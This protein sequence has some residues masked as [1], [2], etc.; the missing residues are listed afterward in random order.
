M[1]AQQGR[2]PLPGRQARHAQL[3]QPPYSPLLDHPRHHTSHSHH[4]VIDSSRL[5]CHWCWQPATTAAGCTQDWGLSW[6]GQ[7]YTTQHNLQHPQ[8][9]QLPEPVLL[10]FVAGRYA[11]GRKDVAPPGG[12]HRGRSCAEEEKRQVPGDAGRWL[13]CIAGLAYQ[14]HT[15]KP[16]GASRLGTQVRQRPHSDHT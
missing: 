11:K 9:E 6:L 7:M 13:L 15:A 10:V 3:K 8:L 1:R 2:R 14:L 16:T 4:T 12:T 5:G